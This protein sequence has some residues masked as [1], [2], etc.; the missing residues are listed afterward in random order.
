MAAPTP[1]D[2]R[3]QVLRE[4]SEYVR[5]FMRDYPELNRLTEGYEHNDR[6]VAAAI[7]D[8]VSDWQSTPP[9]IGVSLDMII[10]N[11]WQ[12]VFHRGVA[13]ALLESLRFLHVRNYLA[14]SEGGVNVQTENPQLLT[15]VIGMM[16]AIYEQKKQKILVAANIS[17]ALRRS[18]VHSEYYFV[19]SYWGAA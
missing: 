5:H 9:F 2:L 14:Y 16:T 11:G 4:A 6:H 18:G 19:N 15:S 7:L 13:I 1:N 10:A 8:T 12:H 3:Q 17:R